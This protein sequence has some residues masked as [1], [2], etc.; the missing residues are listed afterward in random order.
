MAMAHRF[1]VQ[2]GLCTGQDATRVERHLQTVGLPTELAAIPGWNATPDAMIEAIR[3]DKKVSQGSLTFIL[4]RGIGQSFI[5]RSVEA[6]PIRA[7]LEAES[8]RG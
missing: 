1:S 7:F 3:Q 6:A 4:T 5:A 2:Q 8:Q